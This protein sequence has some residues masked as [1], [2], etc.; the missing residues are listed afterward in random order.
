MV[1]IGFGACE[2]E[3]MGAEEFSCGERTSYLGSHRVAI[4]G[5]GEVHAV[6]G[7]HGVDV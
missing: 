1:D 7:E 2:L 4:A 5:R 6:V 3:G